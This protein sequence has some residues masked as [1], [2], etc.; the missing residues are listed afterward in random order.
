V[1]PPLSAPSWSDGSD[2]A[3]PI[4]WAMCWSSEM[5]FSMSAPSVSSTVR[6]VK[7]EPVPRVWCTA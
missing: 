3:D 7:K 2:V 1:E 6:A 4:V 5:P